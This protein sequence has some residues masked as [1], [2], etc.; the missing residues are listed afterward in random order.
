MDHKNDIATEM[1]YKLDPPV[2]NLLIYITGYSPHY[3]EYHPS[4]ISYISGIS[5]SLYISAF[6][7]REN[8]AKDNPVEIYNNNNNDNNSN[9]IIYFKKEVAL[10]DND[11]NNKIL[12]EVAYVKNPNTINIENV[13][14]SDK[15]IKPYYFSVSFDSFPL[16]YSIPF[17][18]NPKD[19]V[20][21]KHISDGSSSNI[22]S[23]LF[24][25][26]KVFYFTYLKFIHIYIVYKYI[27][28]K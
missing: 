14:T 8:D 15:K 5:F 4:K 12:G 7:F 6:V 20:D 21:I 11:Q 18:L 25:S 9:E 17:D 10:I 3:I 19:F 26:E 22:F 24:Q 1:A 27:R 23:A 2:D 28:E 13:F 16:A